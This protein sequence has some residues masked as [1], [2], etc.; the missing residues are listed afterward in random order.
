MKM[1]DKDY[2]ELKTA[3]NK[4]LRQYPTVRSDYAKAKHSATRLRFDLYYKAQD[5][6][7]IA[8]DYT[9]RLRK[10]LNDSHIETA[11][12]KILKESKLGRKNPGHA[13]K[14]APMPGKNLRIK[15]G[16]GVVEADY[17]YDE[18]GDYYDFYLDNTHL[19]EGEPWWVDE[20]GIPTRAALERIYGRKNPGH[21]RNNPHLSHSM[22]KTHTVLGE[23][24]DTY[25]TRSRKG[26]NAFIVR[27]DFELPATYSTRSGAV[28]GARAYLKK[29]K[30]KNP[31]KK[32]ISRREAGGLEE[33]R[34]LVRRLK[35]KGMSTR[36]NLATLRRRWA[37]VISRRIKDKPPKKA[38]GSRANPATDEDLFR[39][40]QSQ[41]K[42]DRRSQAAGLEAYRLTVSKLK[43]KGLST[44]GKLPALK[45]RL[46]KSSKR[47][48]PGHARNNPH[49]SHSMLKTHTVLG[50]QVDTYLTRS[51]KG[52]NAFIVRDDFE[53]PATYSTR[54]G[55]VSGARAYLKKSKRKNPS[56]KKARRNYADVRP[57]RKKSKSDKLTPAKRRKLPKSDFG[58][59]SK[60]PGVGSY[61]I[62]DIKHAAAA[63][64]YSTAA[65]NSGALSKANQDKI[66]MRILAKFPQAAK[67]PSMKK[68]AR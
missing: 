16:R 35:A 23:Q 14:N 37:I 2:R 4:V 30:R 43:K 67:W 32:P 31:S 63:V 48:N 13:R 60:A 26:Y 11:L 24:V 46:A 34:L 61:P 36:G 21:A 45:A 65:V 17:V 68:W 22:L 54:S 25:L 1:L 62:P 27:D 47:K 38:R 58:L 6:G 50:E 33:Y 52:Y 19:N 64:A 41:G 5:L 20:Q 8:R 51:R 55:A 53:L 57:V 39:I 56:K 44:K 15:L 12:K 40:L 18:D 9:N 49:L 3:I 42:I 59:P 28:S 7:H 29:S 66:F 10:Y